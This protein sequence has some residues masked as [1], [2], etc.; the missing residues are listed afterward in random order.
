MFP[1][2]QHSNDKCVCA[3]C[4]FELRRMIIKIYFHAVYYSFVFTEL[5]QA[6]AKTERKNGS[7][8]FLKDERKKCVMC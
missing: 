2:T 8:P 1:I 4:T 3:V 6:E 5:Q 7:K